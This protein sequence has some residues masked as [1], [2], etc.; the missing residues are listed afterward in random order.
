MAR[1]GLLLAIAS[2]SGDADIRQAHARRARTAA[3]VPASDNW[4]RRFTRDFLACLIERCARLS[5]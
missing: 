4:R 3:A 5:T 1:Y 2:H